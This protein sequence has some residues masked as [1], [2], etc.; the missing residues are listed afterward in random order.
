MNRG[1]VSVSESGTTQ[2]FSVSL[3]AQPLSDVVITIDSNDEDEA[4]VSTDTL[5]FTPSNWNNAQTV[6]VTGVDDVIVDGDQTTTLTVAIDDSSSDNAFDGL[7]SQTVVVTTT[8]DDEAGF[9]VNRGT[10][11][12]S[13]SGTTQSF[14]VSLTAQPLSDVVITI[15]SNDEDEAV[16]ST[17]TL[18]FTPSN[19]NNA[20]TVTVTGVDDVIVDGDQTTTL[21]VAIDDS[22]SDNAFDGLNSQTVVVTTTD[23]DEAGFSVNRGT[24][25]VSESG[26]TQSFSVSLTAQPL[27]DVVITI[28]SNDEDEAVVSTDTLTFTPSNWNNAQT[29]TV[30]GVDDVIVDGDQT[31]TLTVAIDDSS[32]DDAFDGL[33]SQTVV[34]TT[35]DDDEAGFSVNR[36]TVSVSESG[37][38][39]SFSV[40]L[41]AQPLSD[42]VITIDSNDEDEAVV[43]TDT[44]TFTPSNWN[45]AQT[46]TVTGVDDVIVDGD[47]TTTLTV[48]IDDSSSDDAF[49]GLNSQTVVVTTTDDDE[50]GFSVNRGT[51]SVSE[52][53]TTQSFSVSLT[54]QPLSDVVIT[55]D[56]NDEDEAVVSTDTLTFTPSNWNNA[57]TVTVTG[58]DDVIVDGDQTT[59]LTVAIDDSSSDDAFDGLNSQTVEATTTDDDVD[60]S[61]F[62]L[63]IDGDGTPM[64]LTD[65]IIILRYLAGFTGTS[66]ISGAINEAGN[67][68]SASEIEAWL[69]THRSDLDVDNDGNAT[70]LTDGILILR[71]LAGFSGQALVDSAVN[72]NG[73]RI[74]AAEISNHLDSLFLPSSGASGGSASA[75]ENHHQSFYMPDRADK[76]KE[77]DSLF[78][79]PKD[80]ADFF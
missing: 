75:E 70:P 73:E 47:Q 44:L 5:T 77:I 30:T 22:S 21:T 29:V 17:D 26:T 24:V 2:S 25:S 80:L 40:S 32:S 6:T 63:D 12:V 58:V 16:V 69:D 28:D 41:T 19:W 13:E 7:N 31:T 51:V 20:Q 74:T 65:G 37:T 35:T 67:R 3:T 39:Q 10:V 62:N 76:S 60:G 53:G 59:T 55:I 38:T 57:Q 72:P 23:D 46:V 27:S 56:S 64:P 50:A 8:D 42:V 34:V 1:T 4:V 14:S 49:D 33:N 48:A 68:T 45:N 15:D 66:L 9:S 79:K 43:S 54:A 18:T 71:F 61:V 52:S 36:G 78:A 11:S